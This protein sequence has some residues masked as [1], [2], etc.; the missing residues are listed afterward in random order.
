[1]V[2]L[3]RTYKTHHRSNPQRSSINPTLLRMQLTSVAL[4]CVLW[5]GALAQRGITAFTGFDCGAQPYDIYDTA[6]CTSI[7]AQTGSFLVGHEFSEHCIGLWFA[8]Q[9][10]QGKVITAFDAQQRGNCVGVGGGLSVQMRCA[11]T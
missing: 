7:N 1:M 10:C 5:A 6:D 11:A 3:P 4:A 2:N 8:Q 9:H